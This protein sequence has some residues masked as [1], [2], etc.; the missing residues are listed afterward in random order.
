MKRSTAARL[1]AA[2]KIDP[3]LAPTVLFGRNPAKGAQ[4]AGLISYLDLVTCIQITD[5]IKSDAK[6]KKASNE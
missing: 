5:E 6:K 1:L 3:V 4:G 2:H